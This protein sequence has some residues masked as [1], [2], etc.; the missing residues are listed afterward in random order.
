MTLLCIPPARLRS[1]SLKLSHGILQLFKFLLCIL[2]CY[3]TM[4]NFIVFCY[5]NV[6][7]MPH[8]RLFTLSV[9]SLSIAK[10]PAKKSRISSLVRSISQSFVKGLH[11][12]YIGADIQKKKFNSH[13]L[14]F[15]TETHFVFSNYTAKTIFNLY[16]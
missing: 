16:S 12:V 11:Q 6:N 14:T 3:D 5:L 1:L 4:T 10:Y 7:F 9:C 15:W 13:L 2:L 8:V